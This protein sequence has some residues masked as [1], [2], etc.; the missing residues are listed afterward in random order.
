MVRI[1]VYDHCQSHFIVLLSLS[2]D[3][4]LTVNI[5]VW[6]P[7]YRQCLKGTVTR[8]SNG[9]GGWNNYL[10]GRLN[11]RKANE[12]YF[13]YQKE[14]VMNFVVYVYLIL[15]MKPKSEFTS[16]IILTSCIVNEDQ[17]ILL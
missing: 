5:F 15:L 16:L 7:C 13:K 9:S 3:S 12:L 8:A 17:V 1:A 4:A 11:H 10:S 2:G 6:I 14:N